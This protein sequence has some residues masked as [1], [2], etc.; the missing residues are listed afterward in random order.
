[1][2]SCL[3]NRKDV[4][5]NQNYKSFSNYDANLTAVIVWGSNSA[6]LNS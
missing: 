2:R 3:R 1:M 5:S 6:T 4:Y